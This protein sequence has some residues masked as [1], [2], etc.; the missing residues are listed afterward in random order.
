MA[1]WS[2]YHLSSSYIFGGKDANDNGFRLYKTN[3]KIIMRRIHNCLLII[4]LLIPSFSN[5]G[6]LEDIFKSGTS[7]KLQYDLDIARLKDLSTL[8][9]H[10]EAYKKRTGHYPFEGEVPYPNYVYIATKEQWQYIQGVPPYQHKF[11]EVQE[12]ITEL[13]AKLG[14]DIEI[15]FDLQR[16][17]VNKPNFYIYM[18]VDDM[19]FLAVHLHHQ[20]P[21][22]NKVSDYYYKVEVTNSPYD[23]NPGT[24]LREQLLTN[25]DY[26]QAIAAKPHKPGYT[27]QLREKLG[28]NQ[29]FQ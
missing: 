13:Q 6:L 19:Y 7:S 2:S 10:L 16:V 15:P 24:W 8:S 29:A 27:E 4:A 22:A 14:G 21:F 11:T 1:I 12:L 26:Q 9:G 20:Q 23:K 5:A 18:V 3:G 17:P 25:P 28:G